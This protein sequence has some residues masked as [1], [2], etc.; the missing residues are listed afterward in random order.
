[1]KDW[2]K[3]LFRMAASLFM[4]ALALEIFLRIYNPF[5]FRVKGDKIVLPVNRKYLIRNAKSPRLDREITH[6]KN[7]IGFRGDEPPADPSKALS[8]IT[9]GG[10]TTECFFLS[11]G[12]TW[13]DLLGTRMKQDFREV[14]LNNAG[15]DGH[16]TFG[17]QVLLE[18]YLCK[19]RPRMVVF[20]V[21]GNDVGRDDLS[22]YDRHNLKKDEKD[23]F[24]AMLDKVLEKSEIVLLSMNL[25]RVYNAQKKDLA[26]K[27]IDISTLESLDI[28]EETVAREV[29]RHR[30]RHIPAYRARL[31]RLIETSRACGIEP[32]FLTQPALYGKGTDQATGVSLETL[33]VYEGSSGKLEWSILE[34]YNEATREVC[35]E[36]GVNFIDLAG[37]MPKNSAY[38]YD[39]IHFTNAGA[40]KVADIVYDALKPHLREKY[41][42]Y[43]R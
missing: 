8:L 7:S 37:K 9:V 33:K 6:T 19:I 3:I 20:L 27:S 23:D 22:E 26:H 15:L 32:L 34:A 5:P 21:G 4:I 17:H 11:D 2:K 12:K 14:W 43:A 16:S 24:S 39:Y 36:K 29:A 25:E 10:S 1:M 13:P 30:E 42:Q 31:L 40:A 35:R 41:G 18:D 28:P 38:Y